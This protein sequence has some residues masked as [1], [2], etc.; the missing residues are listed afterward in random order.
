[1]LLT[2]AQA[3]N[4]STNALT[5]TGAI[6]QVTANTANY[7]RGRGVPLKIP[8]AQLKTNASCTLLETISFAGVGSDGIN[9]TSTNGVR[10]STNATYIFY[11]NS[12][13]PNV[14][15]RFSYSV[16][17]ARGCTAVGTVT[18][19]VTNAFVS[20]TG[21]DIGGGQI[22]LSIYG[23]PGQNYVVQRACNLP[24]SFGDLSGVLT[25][26]TSGNVGLILYT[27]TPGGGCNPAYYRVRAE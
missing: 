8:I 16:T 26:P 21:T 27:N 14:N 13:T 9:L 24:D 23:I 25:A 2:G 19:I 1:L 3:G 12:V 10:L 6:D 4:Y 11:T 18:I 22:L 5:L 17:D 20:V 15:D 7:G